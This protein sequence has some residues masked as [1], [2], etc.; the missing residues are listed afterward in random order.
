MRGSGWDLSGSSTPNLT[1]LAMSD[2]LFTGTELSKRPN[3]QWRRNQD[4]K[5]LSRAN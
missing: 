5:G 3:V 1:P 4:E 2:S